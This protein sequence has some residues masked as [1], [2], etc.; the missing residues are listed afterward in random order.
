MPS[1]QEVI[2]TSAAHEGLHRRSCPTQV[3][4]PRGCN[5]TSRR[6]ARRRNAQRLQD[7]R[8]AGSRLIPLVSFPLWQP[9][10]LVSSATCTQFHWSV[11][12]LLEH[13]RTFAS[14]NAHRVGDRAPREDDHM[15]STAETIR[16]RQQ[17]YRRN[18]HGELVPPTGVAPFKGSDWTDLAATDATTS[19]DE[20]EDSGD[21]G[22]LDE[23]GTPLSTPGPVV[24]SWCLCCLLAFNNV[25]SLAWAAFQSGGVGSMLAFLHSHFRWGSARATSL[26]AA[27]SMR[28]RLDCGGMAS[29]FIHISREI[30][31]AAQELDAA[32]APERLASTLHPFPFTVVGIALVLTCSAEER[33][34]W[35]AAARRAGGDVCW[36]GPSSS[37]SESGVCYHQCMGLIRDDDGMLWVWDDGKFLLPPQADLP[38]QHRA[39]VAIKVTTREIPSLV[40]HRAV[41]AASDISHAPDVPAK[42]PAEPEVTLSWAN[43]N[44]VQECVY[45]SHR[46]QL[47]QWYSF[48]PSRLAFPTNDDLSSM[49]PI[50]NLL[51]SSATQP[52]E[53]HGKSKAL[54]PQSGE[55]AI[56]QPAVVFVSGL[57]MNDDNPSPGSGIARALRAGSLGRSGDF[58]SGMAPYYTHIVGVDYSMGSSGI[59]CEVLDETLVIDS[60]EGVTPRDHARDILR[61]LSQNP[62]AF[63]IPSSDVE[64]VLISKGLHLLRKDREA[65]SGSGDSSSET[66]PSRDWSATA[67]RVLVPLVTA[68]DWTA[69]PCLEVADVLG[70]DVPPTMLIDR[71]SA[72]GSVL[73]L[74]TL[75]S[76]VTTQRGPF[77]VKGEIFGAAMVRNYSEAARAIGVMQSTIDQSVLIQLGVPG[78]GRGVAFAAVDGVLTAAVGFAKAQ[79]TSQLKGWS[80]ILE[81]VSTDLRLR[82]EKLVATMKYTGG[83]ELEYVQ[84]LDGRCAFIDFNA[85]FPAWIAA[86][87]LMQVNLPAALLQHALHEYSKQSLASGA[88]AFT[89]EVPFPSYAREMSLIPDRRVHYTRTIVE[90]LSKVQ[91]AA[92]YAM[93][94]HGM[95][96]D[97]QHH[98]HP[99]RLVDMAACIDAESSPEDATKDDTAE[100]SPKPRVQSGSPSD[101]APRNSADRELA[102]K[103]AK[104]NTVGRG[105]DKYL[106]LMA[107]AWFDGTIDWTDSAPATDVLTHASHQAPTATLPKGSVSM[108]TLLAETPISSDMAVTVASARPRRNLEQTVVQLLPID[109]NG[110][111]KTVSL[112]DQLLLQH[113][114]WIMPLLHADMPDMLSGLSML[115]PSRAQL[116][117]LPTPC[118]LISTPLVKR[119]VHAFQVVLAQAAARAGI[120]Q[121]VI[122]MSV[123]TQ[124]LQAV[125]KAGLALNAY[126]EVISLGELRAALDAGFLPQHIIFNGPG[127]NVDR[128][129]A[130]HEKEAHRLLADGSKTGEKLMPHQRTLSARTPSEVFGSTPGP[131]LASINADS[132]HE[133]QWIVDAILDVN[134]YIK[135]HSVGIRLT[136]PLNISRFGVNGA[137]SSSPIGCPS[138]E[139]Q[140]T[141]SSAHHH[142]LLKIA[143]Q[144]LRLPSDV[145]FGIHFHFASST[146]GWSQWLAALYG[147]IAQAVTLEALLISLPL[148]P[149]SPPRTTSQRRLA[150]F[151]LGGGFPAGLFAQPLV[152]GQLCDIVAYL[153]SQLPNITCIYME[154]GK[155]LSERA[156]AMLTT[157]QH[158]REMPLVGDAAAGLS[159]ELAR[160]ERDARKRAKKNSGARGPTA[161]FAE[162]P[163]SA[164]RVGAPRPAEIVVV[165]ACVCDLGS[166]PTHAHPLM[167]LQASRIPLAPESK[168]GCPADAATSE[169]RSPSLGSWRVFPTGPSLIY[170]RICMEWDVLGLGLRFPD[171]G[172]QAGDKILVGHTGA[173]DMSMAYEFGRGKESKTRQRV[174]PTAAMASKEQT[175]DS[176]EDI[177]VYCI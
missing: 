164:L 60:W 121:S 133:L 135:S 22:S 171:E 32:A 130:E 75:A 113:K 44:V 73:S 94:D 35:T 92:V 139:R 5:L 53:V 169:A 6:K 119:S 151:D 173:Y 13:Y 128:T 51:P 58:K 23:S 68:L 102:A 165:D 62:L 33:R 152:Q 85:R 71:T 163:Q 67:S 131:K 3:F 149:G 125:L 84:G 57:S 155:S 10:S 20:E 79:Q 136:P 19:E 161:S 132:V 177:A 63:W 144:L 45:G 168:N 146:L 88:K 127:K 37:A 81:T 160:F 123:K 48:L 140:A 105:I 107:T 86:S 108:S 82:I 115:A 158:S 65:R 137:S 4:W 12:F 156:G 170:G 70:M 95:A 122:G 91:P 148:Q 176:N 116:D 134:H 100:S 49:P 64:T 38:T 112:P 16:M 47:E 18:L 24:P 126:A 56:S 111:R 17:Q 59:E 97:M 142:S 29:F 166:I 103:D 76:F 101:R 34:R 1:S 162:Q 9:L 42:N 145:S 98:P 11:S 129:S 118:F 61:R 78:I 43:T 159:S 154:P 28:S 72:A 147:V 54:T 110:P 77:W 117:H 50:I 40:P 66:I 120:S 21:E 52:V 172:L 150:F 87:D 96:G 27:A 31:R 138:D 174:A 175:T 141:A 124:P 90:V 36:V 8:F 15:H 104:K 114:L 2:R 157:V 69:K 7:L 55:A 106:P 30:K 143:Q 39:I 14:L 93:F 153:K 25:Y 109:E 41:E 99:A 26:C 89:K 80:G 167:Y 83:G 74:Q 46:L